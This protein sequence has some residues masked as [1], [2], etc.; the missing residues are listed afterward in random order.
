[1]V[2]NLQL[3]TR[4]PQV[5]N[6][7]LL[8]PELCPSSSTDIDIYFRGGRKLHILQKTDLTTDPTHKRAGY[9]HI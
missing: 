2:I 9:G 6:K 1:M 3:K 5:D 4:Y 7:C 8:N